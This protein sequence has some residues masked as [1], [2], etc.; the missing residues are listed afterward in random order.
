M[1]NMIKASNFEEYV[2]HF[3]FEVQEQLRILRKLVK[4]TAPNAT[5]G[6]S[7]GMPAFKLNGK[8]LVYFAAQKNHFGFYATPSAH[9]AFKREL[10]SYKK[11]KGSV[12]FPFKEE[13]PLETIR[14]MVRFKVEELSN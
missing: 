5:E 6:I 3:P 12:Q 13:L 2:A 9:D 7:Y 11:G 14:K 10:A 4:E 1:P 8:P